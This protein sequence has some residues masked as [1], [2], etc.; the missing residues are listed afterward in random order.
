MRFCEVL[1]GELTLLQNRPRA[2]VGQGRQ[3][4][5]GVGRDGHVE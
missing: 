3:A 1:A 5:V 4:C 2:R